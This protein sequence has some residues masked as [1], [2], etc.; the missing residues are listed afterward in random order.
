MK[1]VTFDQVGPENEEPVTISVC[2]SSVTVMGMPGGAIHLVTVGGTYN[3]ESEG[4]YPASRLG[5]VLTILNEG[6][7]SES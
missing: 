5:H 6:L 7:K 3:I 1:F 4:L 2:P